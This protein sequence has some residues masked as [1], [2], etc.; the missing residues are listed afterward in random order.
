MQETHL[1]HTKD[2]LVAL[3]YERQAEQIEY[4]ASQMPQPA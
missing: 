3:A 1:F 2:E 4:S